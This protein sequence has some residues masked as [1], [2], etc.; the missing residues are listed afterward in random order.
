MSNLS[1]IRVTI[2]LIE[3]GSWAVWTPTGLVTVTSPQDVAR[4]LSLVAKRPERV[5]HHRQTPEESTPPVR[6][7]TVEQY[8]A[9]GGKITK[10]EGEVVAEEDQDEFLNSLFD[11]PEGVSPE[12]NGLPTDEE[13]EQALEEN[14]GAEWDEQEEAED[15]ED[16]QPDSLDEGDAQDFLLPATDT[17]G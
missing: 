13:F 17:G 1:K 14:A 12:D 10:C 5:F 15:Y 9:R 3:D 4:I 6:F 7:E 8:L 11:S 2:D 16:D